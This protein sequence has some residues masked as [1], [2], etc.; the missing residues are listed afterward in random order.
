MFALFNLKERRCYGI[1][2]IA[3]IFRTPANA[4][5]VSSRVLA[6]PGGG[7][8]LDA[9]GAA[10]VALHHIVG[11]IFVGKAAV[12]TGKARVAGAFAV[13]AVAVHAAVNGTVEKWAGGGKAG[14][15]ERQDEWK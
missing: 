1:V 14:Q 12:G 5:K 3:R 2:A 8:V 11:T 10:A 6:P 7:I 13:K 15:A 4:I 9:H